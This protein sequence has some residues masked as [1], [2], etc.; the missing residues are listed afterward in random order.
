PDHDSRP[1]YLWPNLLGLDAPLVAVL[2]CWFYAH[3]Q[4]VALPG[5]IFLLLAGAVWSI[6][7]TDRLL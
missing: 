2:W 1:W 4:G 6:Y 3:V 5:S 7:T